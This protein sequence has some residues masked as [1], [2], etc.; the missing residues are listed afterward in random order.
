MLYRCRRCGISCSSKAQYREH[1]ATHT[2]SKEQQETPEVKIM[3]SPEKVPVLG[4]PKKKTSQLPKRESLEVGG[5]IQVTSLKEEV[6]EG[7]DDLKVLTLTPSAS[8][9][10]EVK[11]DV[12][13]AGTEDGDMKCSKASLAPSQTSP[14]Q[15]QSC[16]P[17]SS[18]SPPTFSPKLA[19]SKKPVSSRSA[20]SSREGSQAFRRRGRPPKALP[21]KGQHKM[22]GQKGAVG[23]RKAVV[24]CRTVTSKKLQCP[25]CSMSFKTRS[26][27]S[28]HKRLDH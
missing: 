24:Q 17:V 13:H 20:S 15:S 27:M 11:V 16:S 28:F 9:P 12:I 25:E 26:E 7:E 19:L 1:T 14:K 10:P 4:T 21:P 5:G 2:H 18:S 6:S 22:V 3:S 8:G 23:K